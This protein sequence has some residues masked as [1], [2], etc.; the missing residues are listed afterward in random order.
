MPNQYFAFKQFTV[1]QEHSAMKVGT[2]GVLL[3]SWVDIKD[4]KR[5]LDIGTGTGL[6]ALMLAQKSIA[7]IDAVEIDE[8]ACIDALFNFSSS[9]WKDRIILF[10][11]D[12]NTF[13][14][15]Q[16]NT[17]YQVIV[18]NPPYFVNSLKSDNK[19]KMQARHSDVLTHDD[20]L[21]GV[22]LL[23]TNDGQFYVII[24]FDIENDFV[25]KAR[26]QN[27]HPESYFRIYSKIGHPIPVRSIICFTKQDQKPM[28]QSLFIR[29]K[30]SNEYTAEYKELTKDFYLAF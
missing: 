14:K 9:T 6:L 15:H 19:R 5:V 26:L 10:H 17:E 22:S 8:H 21:S 11:A 4:A 25:R 1:Y 3:G 18:S 12:F 20:L 13:S 7:N 30:E 23:L 2:D 27:L 24:P 28:E 16:C 29:E